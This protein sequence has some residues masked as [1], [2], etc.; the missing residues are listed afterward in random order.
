MTDDKKLLD[1]LRR[2]TAELGQTKEALR[3][4][5]RARHEP[6]AI[7]GMDCRYPGG[8]ASPEDLWNLVAEGTDAI[9]EWP[10]NRG[11]DLE[12][13]YD[14]D[15]ER[16][17]TSYT[18]NGGFLHDADLFDA[19][20]FGI[21]PREALSMDP[22]QRLLLETA[23]TAVER[24]GLDPHTLRG[25]RT[26][27]YIGAIGNGYGDRSR[28]VPE[29]QALLD[30][31]TADSVVSG[32][33][34]YV[35][36]LEGPAVS[37]NT[38]CSSSLVA[39]H[40]AVQALRTGEATMALAG[41]VTVMATLDA[42]I[43]FSRQRGLSP[44]GRCKAFADAADGTGWS[45]GVGVLVLER[46]SDARR[47]GHRILGVIRGSALNQ[48]GASNGLTAPNGPS[49]Q[50]VIKDA[51]ANAQL[52]PG[53]IDAVEAH[54]T[55][56]RLGDPIE[57]QALLATYGR[58]RERPLWL[59]SLKSNLGHSAAAAGVG[60][61]IKMVMAMRHGVLPKTLHVDTPS[62]AVD[63][64]AGRVELLT[65]A[66][67]WEEAGAPRRA[68]VSAFG[69]SGT[70]AH[71]ILEQAPVGEPVES[72]GVS[73]GVVPWVVSGRSVG[74]LRAQ[75]GR[76]VPLVGED[77]AAVGAALWGRSVFEHRAV[78]VGG[79]AE[80]FAAGLRAVA[81]GEA[82]T[83]GVA[84]PVGRTVFVFPG[85]GSQWS[86]MAVELLGSSAVFA[87]RFGECERALEPFVDWSL[88]EVVR[89]GVYDRVDVVQP[90]LWAVMVSLAAVWES[91][92]V[93]PDA[94]VGHSQ[95]EIA[96]AVVAGAL[97]LEDGARVVALRSRAIRGLAGR[98]GMVSVPL[99][100][101]EV[102]GLLPEGVW[103]A[104]V[105]GPLSVVVAGDPAGLET[106]LASV[107]RA[108][109]VPVDYA[110]HSAHVE[111][112]RQ[113]ILDVLAP[114][115]PRA[116]TVPF[117]ST[118][119]V[120][121]A[122]G[123]GL[124]AGYWYRNLRR[125]VQFEAAVRELAGDGYGA[126]VEVSA[127]PVLTMPVEET[128]EDIGGDTAVLAVGTLRRD[129][130]G[131]HR[132]LT[133]A[134]ELFVRGVEVDFTPF[135]G[136][137]PPYRDLPTYAFQHKRYWLE[138]SIGMAESEQ[139]LFWRTVEDG[140][141]GELLGLD[142]RT[143]L[144]DVL[145]ALSDWR[146][147]HDTRATVDSW[148]YRVTWKA[149]SGG[150]TGRWSG[151]C[152][153]LVP[154]TGHPLVDEVCRAL[155]DAGATVTRVELTAADSDR[156]TLARRIAEV[157]RP[158]DRVVSLAGLDERPHPEHAVV[159]V[160][161][162][163]TL[164]LV[165]ALADAGVDA[166]LWCLTGGAVSTGDDGV[167]PRAA[168]N[169]VW[170][171]GRVAALEYPRRWGGLL[172]LAPGFDPAALVTALAG[173][174]DED[175]LALRPGAA[176]GRRLERAPLPDGPAP[177][178]WRPRGTVLITG[179]TGA[180]GG[181]IA[182][183]LARNGAEHLVLLSRQG[184]D[185]PGAAELTAE[186][187]SLGA[188]VT[189]AACDVTDRGQLAALVADLEAR[190]EPVRS[191]MHTAGAGRLVPLPDTDLAEFG[192]TLH[193]K[194]LGA[195]HLD[196]LIGEVDAFVLFSSISAVWGSADHGAYAAANAY[197]DGLAENRRARGLA[198]TSVVWG[199]WAPQDGK[200][201]AANLAERQLRGR[202]IPFMRP[203][204]AIEGFQQVLDRDETV[205]VVAAVDWGRFAPV[206]TSARPS[207]LISDLPDARAALAGQDDDT[208]ALGTAGSPLLDRLRPLS[209]AE[210]R[211]L[212]AELVRTQAAAVLG[213]DSA[214]EIEPG[215]ALR[216]L[217]FDSLTAVE[218]RNRLNAATGLRLPVTVVFDHSS[219]AALAGHLRDELL[220]T[221][222]A[223]AVPVAVTVPAGD[224]PVVIVAASCRYPGGV[225]SPEDL[226]RL[227]AEGRDAISELP[228]DRGWDL[229]GVYDTDPDRPGTTYSRAGGFVYDAGLFDPAFFGIS[230]RE[231]LAMD[232]QQRLLLETSWEAL[233]R[234]GIDP[235]ALRGTPTGVFVGASY[236]GYG[237]GGERVPEEAEGH[238]I[239]GISSSVLS[240][241]VAYALGL[242]GPALTVDT[243][244]SSSL[245]AVHLAA[246]ALRSG[247]CSLALAAGATILG[248]TLSFTG[249]SRQ[250]GLAADGR[251]KPFGAEADGFG[252][253]EGVGV[254]LLER[255]SDARRN[256]HPVL[257]LVR[258]SA[259]NQDGASNGLTA[260]N[261]LSQQRVI[262]QA[263]ANAGLDP[264]D[265][266]VVEAHGTGT[267]L[268]DPIEAQALLATYGQDRDADRPLRLGSVKSNIG[269]TQAASGVAGIIK[270]LQ[271]MRHGTL[272]RT[273]HADVP[274]PF[275][276]WSAGTIELLTEARPWEGPRRA[277]VSSFGMSGTNAHVIIEQADPVEEPAAED[278]GPAPTVAWTLSGRTEEA[279]RDQARALLDRLDTELL[280]AGPLDIAHSLATRAAFERRA[281][282]VGAHREELAAGL[283]AVRDG[284]APVHTA[285][286][287]RR[288]VFVFPGQGTQWTGMALELLESAPVF[289][290]RFAECERALAPHLDWSPSEV[291][292]SGDYEQVDRIQPVLF[293]VMV[294]LAA[295]WRSCGVEPD[296][297]VGHSQGEIAAACVAGALSLED[298]ATVVALRSKAL[299]ALAGQGTM[300]FVAMA[301]EPLRERVSAWGGRIGVAAVNGPA[302]ATVSGDPEALE[303]LSA[304]LSDEGVLRWPIPG[305]D[306][307]AHSAQ[308]ER[309]HDELLRVLDGVT[310]RP[311]AVGFWSTTAG[312]WLDG[313]ALDA[314]YW[315]RNLRETVEFDRAVHQLIADG[316]DTFVEVS[317]NPVL[318]IWV[319]QA[320]EAA[321]GGV[322]VGTLHREA[323]G[324]DR[325]LTS[326]GELYACGAAVDWSA[327]HRGGRRVDL[328]TYPFQRQHYW[329]V[330]RPLAP[331]DLPAAEDTA[332]WHYRVEWRVRHDL[333]SRRATGDWLVVTPDGT[334]V[335]AH[336]EALRRHGL[337]PLVVPWEA[338][339]DRTTG[340]ARLRAAADGHEPAGVLSL[341]GLTDRPWSDETVLPA[342]LPMT[343]ALLGALG[344]AGIDAP[345]WAATRGA[346]SVGPA[347]PVTA[348][349][350]AA[351]WGL[352]GA[353]G[354]EYPDRWA[355]LVDLPAVLD[356]QAAQRLLAVLTGEPGEDQVALRPS[357]VHCRRLAHAD[358]PGPAPARP[359]QPGGTV[360][361]TGGLGALGGHVARWLATAGAEHLLLT[362]RRGADTPGADELTAELRALGVHVTVAACD[363]ADRDAVAELLAGIPAE[364]PLTAVVHAAGVLDD[365]V[366]DSLTAD[367][368]AG[369]ARPKA[370]AALV[371][372]ELT[373]ETD[374]SAFVLFSSLAST[375]AGTGQGGYAA[376][377]AFLDAL[378]LHRR[379]LGLPA[380]SVSWGLWGGR[381][382]TDE[383]VAARLVRDG[384]PAMD[385]ARAVAALPQAVGSGEPHVIVSDFAWDRFVAAFTSLRPSPL[386]ADLPE[387]AA[388]TA[389]AAP[390]RTAAP[391]RAALLE[392][393]RTAAAEA[394]GHDGADAI[395]R[396]R[397]F[398]D[399]G[400][401]S[402]TAVELRNKL[403]A[404]TGLRLPVTLVFD[405]PT[406]AA[407]VDHLMTELGEP[408][409]RTGTATDAAA[410][411]TDDPV[412]VVGLS[413]RFP[414]GVRT[415]EDF[416]RLISEGGDAITPFPTDRGWDLDALYDPDPGHHGTTYVREG[417]FLHDLADFDPAFFG[418]SPR[419][420]A[421][422]DPQQR[423]LL[424]TT[425]EAFE[426]VGIDPRS[427]KGSRTGVFVGS[428]YHDYGL[429]VRNAP[430]EV[431][432]YLG[433]GSAGSV[434]S[435]RISYTFGLEGPAVSVDTACSSSLV[436]IHLAAQSLRSGECTLAL[437]GGAAAMATPTSFI[438]FSRQ[439]GLSADGRCKPFAAAADGT[440]W[441]EGVGLVVLER[442]SDARRHGH[443]VL[444]LVRGSA[445]NQDGASNGLT[446]PNGPSQQR[447]IRDALTSAR[448]T[449]AELDVV[450]AHGTGTK[451]GD[452]IEAQA[453]LAT[454]GQDRD[455][456]LL[457]GS[458]K[459]NIGHAQ[460]AAGIAGVI[461]MVL[462]M[463][464][465]TVPATLHVDEPSP[466][467]DWSAGR[468]DLV[469]EN[470]PW[471]ETGHPR[472]AAVSSFGVSGTNAHTILEQAPDDEPAATA[473]RREPLPVPLVLSARSAPALRAQ[474]DLLD[475]HLADHPDLR[476]ADVAHTLAT[477]R[478][479]LE[480]RAVVPHGDRDAVRAAL[481]SVTGSVP[482]AE[483][484]VA[485]LF[486]GQGSQRPG[487]GL[488]LHREFP[489]FAA[490]FDAVCAALDP[491]LDRPLHEVLGAADP[492]D[493]GLLD[494]TAWTQPALFA[495]EVALFRL[496]EHWG[497]CPDLLL[498]HS[499][500]ELAAAHVAGVLSLPDAA[501]LVAERAR[502]MQ[503]M[504]ADGAMVSVM[505]PE[506]TVLPYL[507]EYGDRVT[508]AAVNS[509]VA[510][511]VAGDEDAVLGL[512]DR[513][514]ADGRKTRRL[515]VSHAFHSPHMDAM[516]EEFGQV[517]ARLEYHP[518]RIPVVSNVTGEIAG[519]DELCTPDYWVR[520]VRGT[521]RF[522]DGVRAL[523]RAGVTA[524]VEIGP[525]GSLTAPAQ[526]CLEHPAVLIPLLHRDRDETEAVTAA[527]GRYHAEVAAPDWE[528]VL[529]DRDVRRV[530]LPTYAFQRERHWLDD[531]AGAGDV[532]SAGLL[533]TGHPL[534][535]A[536]VEV[537]G[538]DTYVFTGR[539]SPHDTPWLADHEV[540]EEALFPATAFLEL[541]VRAADE[542]G[543]ARVDELSLAAP[544]VLPEDGA[545]VLQMRVG[546][547]D[548]DGTR[549]LEVFSRPQHAPDGEGWTR[550]ADG[551][552]SPGA[553]PVAPAAAT[554]TQWPPPGAELVDVT[555]L[556][557]RFAESGFAYGPAFQGLTAVWRRGEEVFA[558]AA[559]PASLRSEAGRFGLHPALLD[560]VLH[561][562]AFGVL[563]GSGRAWLPFAWSGVTLHAAGAAAVRLR[564]A[565]TGDSSMSVVLADGTGAPV[566][567]A[568]SLALRPAAPARTATGGG[569]THRTLFRPEFTEIPLPAAPSPVPA[570]ETRGYEPGQDA[571][572]VRRAT[573]RALADIRD[574]LAADRAGAKLVFTTRGA[575]PAT[576]DSD[577]TDLAGAAVWG[578][579]RSAQTEHPDRFVLVDH[580]YE[581]RD[582]AAAAVAR[583]LA[584]AEPQI[585]LRDGRAYAHRIARVPVGAADAAPQ[586]E[587]GGTV[588]VTGGTGAIG[589]H[590]SR[591]LVT[592]HGV[593]RL[594]LTSR[595][596]PAGEGT[597]RLHREL[598]AL[599]A[600]VEV[601][602]CDVADR[603]ALA[604]LLAGVPS[605][606]P[607]TAVVHTAGVVQDGIVASITDEQ[608]DA[609]LRP[610]VDAVLNLQ[611]LTGPDLSA[612][613]VFSSI[614]GVFGGMGQANYAAANAF[615]DA[616]AHHRRAR[617]LPAASLAWGLWAND[618]GMSGHLDANDFKRIA[619]GGIIPF[620]P[621]EGLELFDTAL[622]E[623]HPVLLPLRLD[624]DAV[625]AQGEVPAVLRGLVR[626]AVRRTAAGT[627][628][629]GAAGLAR[630]LSAMTDTQR[631]RALLDLVRDHA[632]TV[633][634]FADAGS[635]DV[636]RGLLEV[637]FDSLTAVELRNRLGAAS[638]LRLPATLLFDHPTCRAV[639]GHLAD[640][641]A[642]GPDTGQLPGLAEL[643]RLS[644]LLDDERHREELTGR[645]HDL[646]AK[647]R[648]AAGGDV[649]EERLDA[650]D[651]D[652]I[653]AFIDNELG[654]S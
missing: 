560:S 547:Q 53:D 233:E 299:T 528:R 136:G 582:Q 373:R 629:D 123:T 241:R 522:L 350:Q 653:F 504:R 496:T 342:A 17:G 75:A 177:A 69:V 41:G 385:P 592:A 108:R 556:Y 559:L 484:R 422:I 449:P 375:L 631:R 414:G 97:S 330:P 232:P 369:V 482:P 84:G 459:S 508:V 349:A 641:L 293:S 317:P 58:H 437:A 553:T 418:I 614:A 457:L 498:G 321:D 110:S 549:G 364:T 43:A 308:V 343:V 270:M 564:M 283:R 209:A 546:P 446:A 37:V 34:S 402:L 534:I 64:S 127:H 499:V 485:F 200:G 214:A 501:L 435:G 28:D 643:E 240:G 604:A 635:L 630:R 463:R 637:G 244:C 357:G 287:G 5:R 360:L 48:D 325:F 393:V 514:A 456:P 517:A 654:M 78:V 195:A 370:D 157:P 129:E 261:G 390:E 644:T 35:L 132:F 552:L 634:G 545:V 280:D 276:D 551:V 600:H 65:E 221:A 171:L 408:D 548:A 33:V 318:A 290:E 609:T 160:G 112:I 80:E 298:A 486:A 9:T 622:A 455:R 444:A 527:L 489:V 52:S 111:E 568:E 51:L 83:G 173:H 38:A 225:R 378:A 606:H 602:A 359:W 412:A 20:F 612:F 580:D 445:V 578:L 150:G 224:D 86:G 73:S 302:S 433:I 492:E 468:V 32:R 326:L 305:A 142:P 49:Q 275:V 454:Y 483:P 114:V 524:Y 434:A 161:T 95:G 640:E 231:A 285:D 179:G 116:S 632:A 417:G 279:V 339:D 628:A 187:E 646:L 257:A 473:G 310:P 322:V 272:P 491:L 432:G 617:G 638:G 74:A 341:L 8:V 102:R 652:E 536:A 497:L 544:L 252:I 133:S 56:T 118:V 404:A 14:P 503:A 50:R 109:R 488:R 532:T 264:A 238:L 530:P 119:D 420:A 475:R 320:M 63:W 466:F 70:N 651:D 21:S 210:Q 531:T 591:H 242:E 537:A 500:G 570:F 263:L 159:P 427:V 478:A 239:A 520:H 513:L 196:E 477:A 381:S 472:R 438:E 458:V 460:A 124:D 426:R 42:Y 188:R 222:A 340:A 29:L 366:V 577:V 380:T 413:C 487:M 345:L 147:R 358:R 542:V 363:V 476:L 541:A 315:Y 237:G 523:E 565:P 234:G 421:T 347:D 352:G 93:R 248:S 170:G 431:E 313:S 7:V 229:G 333:P 399:L 181:Q 526:D 334:D 440:A 346:V 335:T 593:K 12:G 555:G 429:R 470:T 626:P 587:R 205:V 558:E 323:G 465:G 374:L 430:E 327:V 392:L 573:R 519:A 396:D 436:A 255:L 47:N 266:P 274:S 416:W 107:E 212:L 355:G 165:Q 227:L 576:P 155:E 301:A 425:W 607:V 282:V 76:L 251:C 31:G 154:E 259:V 192:D 584:G 215:R 645:L 85:Q 139:N 336:L 254:L 61:V 137:V 442:L 25:T 268:G 66:R 480:H 467:V 371:L 22:Q 512:A 579:V 185:A 585:A 91:V 354:V 183:W 303:E 193:A 36:G 386:I 122:D 164:A 101:D 474:A 180:V 182:A 148:R 571:A 143:P 134:G 106:V 529:E 82:L 601:A 145:P 128:V 81:E 120:E 610:K 284:E 15:P 59:G 67:E 377:N 72:A 618:T 24:A 262:Q 535:G 332:A 158:L 258:G 203:A 291:L 146:N 278:D 403:S 202:G 265:V 533:A 538:T 490:A 204:L 55:G 60:G 348:P 186:L 151:H 649:V 121:W 493:A 563:S 636:D 98:G 135:Y 539:L 401:D 307:A 189:T 603:D 624:T 23:W 309:I 126:F 376:A 566:A 394:L 599:G 319:Q 406:P 650:A 453:L 316:Y 419:E 314:A 1:Y 543:C 149:L 395:G 131:L 328:P 337:T 289:A 273:L 586:W 598:T 382:L 162:A 54:G 267:K 372:H 3:E 312:A 331:R 10:A 2:A 45:E 90:V 300:M 367:R 596:G 226:W 462:A 625:Q 96:A 144:S 423:L 398:K 648:G 194:V 57:A 176:Y 505:A 647:A 223:P 87:A 627:G 588:L 389:Q 304:A 113:E 362:G 391:D 125:P 138:D 174:G 191:V 197:L 511:V 561:S 509:T 230:P 92:G 153:L 105:N 471:P 605:E 448:L 77:R 368:A 201:M 569:R 175:Q 642:P 178:P 613:V 494:R 228:G 218:L 562:L 615:L 451:L 281:V 27:V 169:L 411:G 400:C 621:A 415:P 639:A 557:E 297:V 353:A 152:L 409:V 19:G 18:R 616:L 236:Q 510:T 103:V 184:S 190:G 219:A 447:V 140:G 405:H 94:V 450:E 464:H 246:Q 260:P 597:A 306:F 525:D 595:T 461:K 198:A 594:L 469:T 365:G 502:L 100:V 521:V 623:D 296:A 481:R 88:A 338:A 574:W 168:Q 540:F 515:R 452:P 590:V 575:V 172:D 207:P 379:D 292:R 351:L 554:L 356:D 211:E 516:L 277:G 428:S 89:S 288:T 250:R 167:A 4:A 199:I 68:G 424:E 583:V 141:L 589:A 361:V 216:E 235:T 13:R 384:L 619:R 311:A 324:P 16:T 71:V 611:D 506:E 439:R 44:D 46:L 243:A 443:P 572:A 329:L 11:W 30:T 206:F 518:P 245:V 115:S 608:L 99:P 271:A 295:L 217:G 130:G 397:V 383:A 213:H 163:L 620:P 6:I 26:G 581:D 479:H 550:H 62:R 117:F 156:R 507:A 286:A 441:A 208:T 344:D 388:L 567:T 410:A 495:V 220:G 256:G 39:I 166:T 269:H 253:A 104:A 79:S 387:V 407:V 247:E 249:F 294:S 633:L 40:L